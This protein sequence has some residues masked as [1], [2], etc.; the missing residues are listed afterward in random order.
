M[1][2]FKRDIHLKAG[3]MEWLEVKVE[4]LL[5]AETQLRPVET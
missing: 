3:E 4:R 2:K 5:L 1:F